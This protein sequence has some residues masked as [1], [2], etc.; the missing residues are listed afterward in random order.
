VL[1]VVLV[2][3]EGPG[4]WAAELALYSV[5]WTHRRVDDILGVTASRRYYM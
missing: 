2:V 1:V 4:V 5:R 3:G